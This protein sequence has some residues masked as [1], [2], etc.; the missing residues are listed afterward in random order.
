MAVS[1]EHLI[2]LKARFEHLRA[3]FRG[4]IGP[5]YCLEQA[6]LALEAG[7][8]GVG[9]CLVSPSGDV[10]ESGRNLVFQ[11]RF[12]SMAHAEMVL[13]N[14]YEE[15]GGSPAS[16]TLYTSL[17]PCVMCLARIMMARVRSVVFLAPGTPEKERGCLPLAAFPSGFEEVARAISV[18]QVRGAEALVDFADELADAFGD[19]GEAIDDAT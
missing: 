16:L 6:L 8:F 2:D 13:L 3:E 14:R 10:V 7:N 4:E 17:E 1:P 18:T 19:F 5:I 11:P 15:M 9:A 12:N